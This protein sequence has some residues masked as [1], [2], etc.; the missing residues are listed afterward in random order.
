MRVD[1]PHGDDADHLRMAALQLASST[2]AVAGHVRVI[3]RGP[4]RSSIRMSCTRGTES[5]AGGVKGT[6]AGL[7][8]EGVA[9]ARTSPVLK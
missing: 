8:V 9:I 7:D 1:E 2:S 5:P 6:K 3:V 4:L